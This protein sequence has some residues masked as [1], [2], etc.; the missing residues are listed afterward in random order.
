MDVSV[1]IVNYNTS[2]LTINAINSFIE[3]SSGFSYEIIVVDNSQTEDDY[4]ALSSYF[5]KNEKIKIKY[6]G[7][8]LGFGKGNNLG[9]LNSIGEYIYFLNEDTLQINNACFELLNVIRNNNEIGA[10]T[11]NL[12]KKDGVTPTSSFDANICDYKNE[13]KHCSFIRELLKKK[14][15]DKNSFNYTD[16]LLEIKGFPIM[17]ST[18]V[19]RSDFLA[20]GGFDKDI[21]LY[22]EDVL[23][24]YRIMHE[25]NKKII[26]VP[27]SKVIHL[28]GGSDLYKQTS[29]F[30][31]RAV[32]DG[33]TIYFTKTYGTKIAY[34]VLKMQRKFHRKCYFAYAL[35]LKKDHKQ[36]QKNYLTA[37]KEEIKKIKNN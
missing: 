8:N 12:Y 29:L 17:A 14:K 19:R 16:E 26:S 9:V 21:F 5:S 2:N 15:L 11:S 10:V 25:L 3:K 18:M 24:G 32:M 36:S 20:L 30:K 35:C 37:I 4:K 22:S 33:K 1:I 28:E 27:S 6:S 34:K 31:A 23:L 7:S 13:K